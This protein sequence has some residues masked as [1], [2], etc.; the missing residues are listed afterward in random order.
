MKSAQLL[1]SA[2]LTSLVHLA[3]ANKEPLLS[4][5]IH[6]IKDCSYWYDNYGKRTCESIRDAWGVS[7]ED[8]ARWKPSLTVD[9]KGW[10]ESIPTA[11][12]SHRSRLLRQPQRP[13]PQRP[14]LR[15]PHPLCGRT[16]V[17][18]KMPRCTRS[19]SS[20]PRPLEMASPASNARVSA[21]TPAIN[22][23]AS[24][25]GTSAGAASTCRVT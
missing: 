25:P 6:T 14:L 19:R 23:S 17:A 4:Y 1:S 24:R 16:V 13:L 9:C 15:R 10:G 2:W 5:D 22:T 21:G 3:T 20:W 12:P 18:T 7:P 8:F 11:L